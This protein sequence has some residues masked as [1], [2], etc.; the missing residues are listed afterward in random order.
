M[1]SSPGWNAGPRDLASSSGDVALAS[2]AVRRAYHTLYEEYAQLAPEEHFQTLLKELREREQDFF[3]AL[4]GALRRADV[5]ATGVHADP[6]LLHQGRACT[7]SRSRMRFL[8]TTARHAV[9]FAEQQCAQTQDGDGRV[10]WE[11]LLPLPREELR[12]HPGTGKLRLMIVDFHTHMAPSDQTTSHVVEW[13]ASVAG[14]HV[15]ERMEEQRTPEGALRILDEAGVD[16]AV[17]LAELHP[18][19]TGITT[20]EY[21]AEYCSASPRLIPF[22]CLNPHLTANPAR[23]LRR[24][25]EQLGMR[26]LKLSPSY[27]H[28]YPSEP[29]LYPAYEYAQAAGIPLLVHTGTSV[30]PGSKLKYA[31][32]LWLDEVAVDFPDLV[33]V[34]AHAGRGFWYDRAFTLARYHPNVYMDFAGLPP[35][36]LLEYFPRLEMLADKA[37]FGTD[38]P[39]VPSL[40]GNIDAVRSLPLQ[41]EAIAKILGL[42][43]A[44]LLQ[45][46]AR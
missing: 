16:Y 19:V 17:V 20:N 12:T 30:F 25:V 3:Y 11:E 24:Y 46:E 5:T 9:A 21:V 31:D 6:R 43:A 29:T 36:N 34:Q 26:G 27:G 13:T 23:D 14:A 2:L 1:I 33:I 18:K 39:G 40:R 44:K 28:F 35:Q 7:T 15:R 42:N 37:L 10:L 41:G 22:A 32:P 45:L 38:Y 4:A 8:L